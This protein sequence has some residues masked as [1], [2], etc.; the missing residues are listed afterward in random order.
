M[1]LE[2]VY[3]ELTAYCPNCEVCQTTNIT[4]NGTKTDDVPYGLAADNSVPMGAVVYI[5]AGQGVLDSAKAFD[6]KWVVD[7]RGGG[8]NIESMRNGVLRLDV[9]VKSCSWAKNF[10]RRR[11]IV[12]L[13]K[14]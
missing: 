5:P 4:Y 1:H 12:F 9:R 3:A 7:D 2:P 14:R 11:L 13:E 6:R 8:L 10:G